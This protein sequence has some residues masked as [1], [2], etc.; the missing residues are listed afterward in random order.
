MRKVLTVHLRVAARHETRL[1]SL[2]GAI[3]KIFKIVYPARFSYSF[4]RWY[5]ITI[6]QRPRLIAPK[7]GDLLEHRRPP[8]LL[9]TGLD[10]FV[11][12]LWDLD[13]AEV[14]VGGHVEELA[15]RTSFVDSGASR[16]YYS[17]LLEDSGGDVGGVK[18][19][20]SE[21][22]ASSGDEFN[23][24][25]GIASEDDAG[26]GDKVVVD[27]WNGDSVG[28]VENAGAVGTEGEPVCGSSRVGARQ[29]VRSTCFEG[30]A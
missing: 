12:S 26:S 3:T 1:K 24:E 2:N 15:L 30:E 23:V 14:D 27:L 13:V 19:A 17:S 7:V 16:N 22:D 25:C 10:R 21:D 29:Q 9:E 6:N 11:V 5:L 8:A 4:P 20:V 28:V 18:F